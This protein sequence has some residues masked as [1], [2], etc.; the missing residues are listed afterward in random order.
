[1][2]GVAQQSEAVRD[3]STDEFEQHDAGGDDQRERQP[4]AVSGV[5][6]YVAVSVIVSVVRMAMT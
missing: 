2:G 6:V 1:M 3:Q 4:S 5:N